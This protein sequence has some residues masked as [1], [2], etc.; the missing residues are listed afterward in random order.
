M[1][2]SEKLAHLVA[3]WGPKSNHITAKLANAEQMV[4][5]MAGAG[6][7]PWSLASSAASRVT[8]V[9]RWNPPHLIVLERPQWGHGRPH[10]DREPVFGIS[11]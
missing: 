11:L 3:G 10:Q 5:D 2:E 8:V 4:R 9:P 6:V 7:P 1:N